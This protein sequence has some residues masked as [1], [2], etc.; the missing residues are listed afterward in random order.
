MVKGLAHNLL[1]HHAPEH[2]RDEAPRGQRMCEV[3][4]LSHRRKAILPVVDEASSSSEI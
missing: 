1:S 2:F 4:R 3:P